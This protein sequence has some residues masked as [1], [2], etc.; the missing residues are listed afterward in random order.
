MLHLPMFYTRHMSF[1][2][3]QMVACESEKRERKKA[4]VSSLAALVPGGRAITVINLERIHK[5]QGSKRRKLNSRTR[6]RLEQK[7]GIISD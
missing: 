1:F 2:Y 4:A 3:L 7:K 6:K 5:R